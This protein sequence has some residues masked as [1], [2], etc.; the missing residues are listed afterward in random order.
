MS[1]SISVLLFYRV[2]LFYF[3]VHC[4][5]YNV[6]FTLY[7]IHC[8]LYIVSFHSI[9]ILSAHVLYICTNNTIFLG[10]GKFFF[11]CQTWDGGAKPNPLC[12]VKF[13]KAQFY[14]HN[15]IIHEKHLGY[16]IQ[17]AVGKANFNCIGLNYYRI[18]PKF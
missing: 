17:L 6:Q 13:A 9:I 10:K 4:M 11:T 1:W 12:E 7:T 8:T 16:L 14:N 15:Q 5:M 2:N 3:P 18:M